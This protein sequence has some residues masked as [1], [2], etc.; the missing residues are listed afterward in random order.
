[1]S[2]IG[3]ESDAKYKKNIYRIPVPKSS[4]VGIRE[5]LARLDIHSASMFPDLGGLGRHVE[6]LHIKSEEG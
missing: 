1:M 5:E 3:L 4:F 6:W 2:F